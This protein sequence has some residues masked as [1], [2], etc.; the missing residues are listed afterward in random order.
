MSTHEFTDLLL[1]LGVEVRVDDDLILEWYS[2]L[3]DIER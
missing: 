1:L 3:S 2:R